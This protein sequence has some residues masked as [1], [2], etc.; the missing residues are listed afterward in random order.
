M[1]KTIP[2]YDIVLDDQSLTQGVGF[3]SLVDEPAIQVDWIKLA[4]ESSVMN[5]KVSKDRQMLYGPFLIPNMLIYR[6]DDNMGEYYVRFKADQIEKIS[7]KFNKDLN[8]RNINLQHSDT[9][10][11]GYVAEN[12]IIDGVDKSNKLG[13]DL[14][15][16]TWFG[17]VKIDDTELWNSMIKSDEVKGF[18]VEILADLQLELNKIKN[19]DNTM[20]N[21]Q[22]N[23]IPEVVEV[24]TPIVEEIVELAVGDTAVP[25]TTPTDQPAG[26]ITPEQV[27]QMIDARFTELMNEIT[28][29][30]DA[31]QPLIDMP[32]DPTAQMAE[33]TEKL[34]TVEEK[35]ASTP[36]ATTI[37]K[38]KTQLDISGDNFSKEVERI[39]QFAKQK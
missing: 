9:K 21:T 8:S 7:S 17:G 29:I 27:S 24:V 1:K 18:S 25:E 26:P 38:K 11:D 22:E 34:K 2:I 32:M 14:P 15:Q 28:A 16:G 6:Y 10:V 19:K 5:F 23:V 20:E 37:T 36:G 4:K 39:K 33:I 30:K 3:I 13:F 12:W 35:L 31:I